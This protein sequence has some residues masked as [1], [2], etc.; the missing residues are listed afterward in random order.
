M[1]IVCTW[2]KIQGVD[3]SGM[4]KDYYTDLLVFKYEG[5]RDGTWI[6]LYIYF[7]WI[8]Q[9]YLIIFPFAGGGGGG[10]LEIS[11]ILKEL[12]LFARS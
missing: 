6:F 7:Y 2:R 9:D 10:L 1:Y 4:L 8:G 12:S 11:A 5:R 3:P